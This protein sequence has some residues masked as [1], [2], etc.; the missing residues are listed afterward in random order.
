[1]IKLNLNTSPTAT[2]LLSLA[3]V[4]TFLR[5]TNTS[6]DTLITSLIGAAI[7]VA[8]NYTNSRFLETEYTLYMETWTDIYVS[9][10]YQ[11][12][13]N[14]GVYITNGGYVGKD[15]LNQIVLPYAPLA[16]ITHVKYYDNTGTQQTMTAATDYSVHN[17]INQKGFIEI[18]DGI[19][20]P[21]LD[22]R[23][24]AVEIK[25]KAGYGT[26]ADDVPDAIKSAIQLIIGFMYEKREDTVSRLPKASEYLLDPY[27]FKTY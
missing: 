18:M 11:Q 21:T 20:L 3:D 6:E 8:Q 5:V 4:K 7:D 17:F 26:S 24:D 10:S 15:G 16:S 1:M 14:N 13:L 22:D 23:A 27:R 2:D 12:A 9:N 25:F 19:S